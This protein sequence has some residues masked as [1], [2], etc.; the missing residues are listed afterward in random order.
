M[1][2]FAE[3]ES[4]EPAFAARVRAAFDAHAHKFL[5]TLRADGSP[6]ISGIEMHFVADEPWLAGM[7]G[8]VKFTDLRRDPRFALHSGSSEPDAFEADA[9]LSGR[10]RQIT[11]QDERLRYAAAAGVA[12]EHM[13]FELFSVDLE[14]VVLVALND[15]KTALLVT[16]W[17]PGRGLTTTARD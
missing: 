10:A 4:A 8:S 16:S 11:D 12:P 17:R 7:P 5:A 15:E 9:K 1:A 3:V 13:G 6:R 2:S 14:Q